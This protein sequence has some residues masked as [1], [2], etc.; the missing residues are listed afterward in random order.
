MHSFSHHTAANLTSA[1]F[2]SRHILQPPKRR[3][4]YKSGIRLLSSCLQATY[5]AAQDPQYPRN[6]PRPLSA[7]YT[8]ASEAMI[9]VAPPSLFQPPMRQ[10]RPDQKQNKKPNKS[11]SHLHGSSVLAHVVVLPCVL[12]SYLHGSTDQ[13]MHHQSRPSFLATYTAAH[14]LWKAVSLD[15]SLSATYTA[16]KHPAA[17]MKIRS[18]LSAT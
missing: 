3:H 11:F 9:L 7:T 12:F 1:I 2:I 4:R 6:R 17:F 18:S 10:Q 5:A 15:N 14:G 8:A 13:K 16:A